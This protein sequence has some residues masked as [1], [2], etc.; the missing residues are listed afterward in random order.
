MRNCV[1]CVLVCMYVSVYLCVCQCLVCVCSY[2]YLYNFGVVYPVSLCTVQSL[3]P[4]VCTSHVLPVWDRLAGHIVYAKVLFDMCEI[5]VV[6]VQK[7]LLN[8]TT[9]CSL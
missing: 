6:F 2:M 7:T 8:H 9:T 5:L 1:Q 4:F 3:H